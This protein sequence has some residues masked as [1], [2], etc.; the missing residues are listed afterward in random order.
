[1][2]SQPKVQIGKLSDLSVDIEKQKEQVKLIAEYLR[3]VGTPKE[4]NYVEYKKRQRIHLEMLRYDG[5]CPISN[6]KSKQPSF[7]EQ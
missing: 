6:K 3:Y 4:S 2:N 1:V 5:Q 7:S